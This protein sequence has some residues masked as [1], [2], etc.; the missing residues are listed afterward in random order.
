MKLR[1]V[2][3]VAAL[4]VALIGMTFL[5]PTTSTEAS[6]RTVVTV[7]GNVTNVTP[8]L[9]TI[10]VTAQASGPTSGTLTGQGHD[11]PPNGSGASGAPG[12]PGVCP[13]P[14]T[15]SLSGSVV[16]LSGT[17]SFSSNPAFVGAPVSITANASTGAIT[18]NFAGFIFTGTGS[19]VVR[20]P[21]P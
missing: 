15:G 17:V 14:L 2:A 3:I 4:G 5:G 8:G 1:I 7:R 6:H 21:P 19:V 13:F 20:Q 9:G 10:F 16:T 12:N 11:G 18:F